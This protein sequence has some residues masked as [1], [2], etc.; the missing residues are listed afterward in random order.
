MKYVQGE[1]LTQQGLITGYVGFEPGQE[2]E[3]RKGTPPEK[4]VAK[5]FILPAC[6]NAHTHLGDSFIR[7]KHL[8]LPRSVQEL[9][10]PPAG[11]KHRLLNEATEQEILNGIQQSLAE[12]TVAG[13]SW[14]CD[15]G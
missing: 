2:G 5:G 12:M 15:F 6:V 8:E 13:T 3:I 10:A 4:P 7:Y 9:V 1:V 14:F 11:L